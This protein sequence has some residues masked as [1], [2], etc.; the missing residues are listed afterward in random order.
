MNSACRSSKDDQQHWWYCWCDVL[1]SADNPN[2][3]IEHAACRCQVC[4]PTP[5]QK[6]HGIAVCQGLHERVADNPSFTSRIITG[7]K[8]WVYG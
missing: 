8:S 7:D 2:V 1:V 6:E 4:P 3:G 5:E